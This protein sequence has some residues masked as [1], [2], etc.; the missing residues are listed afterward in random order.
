MDSSQALI[1]AYEALFQKDVALAQKELEPHSLCSES[2]LLRAR[3]FFEEGD[4]PSSFSYAVKSIY[5]NPSNI[6]AWAQVRDALIYL[7]PPLSEVTIAL[8]FDLL[9]NNELD[10]QKLSPY[11]SKALVPLAAFSIKELEQVPLY[12]E[13]ASKMLLIGWEW[14]KARDRQRHSLLD[15]FTLEATSIPFLA[16]LSYQ[17][18]LSHYLPEAE[19]KLLAKFQETPK[20]LKELLVKSCFT[21]L[22]P[23]DFAEVVEKDSS[24][25]EI[26]YKRF[27]LTK[28]QPQQEL[29]AT[30]TVLKQFYEENPYPRWEML[31]LFPSSLVKHVELSIEFG[32]GITPL[33]NCLVAGVGTGAHLL[34]LAARYP[35][36][37]FVGIDLSQTSLAFAQS[38][39]AEMQ[40]INP[41]LFNNVKLLQADLCQFSYPDGFDQPNGFDWIECVGVIHHLEEPAKGWKALHRLGKEKALLLGGVYHKHAR[42]QIHQ[43]KQQG[44]S[45]NALRE[46][47][48]MNPEGFVIANSPDFYSLHSCRDLLLHP[49][50]THYTLTSLFQELKESGWQFIKI[51]FSPVW[52]ALYRN[53]HPNDYRCENIESLLEFEQDQ[54]SAFNGM[55]LFWAEKI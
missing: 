54:P 6:R 5:A 20:N 51:E 25:Y 9:R 49:R 55:I 46:K 10:A 33:A 17:F 44:L 21:S 47:I 48:V 14:E 24:Y 35:Q 7:S 1:A 3:L 30:D 53:K 8:I 26:L 2:L 4:F 36:T 41:H 38:K 39:M 29:K 37:K 22:K 34:E 19:D 16:A 27:S 15:P 42:Q 45:L 12:Q 52:R 32:R 43:F 50:E 13:V 28:Q 11:L 18:Y 23:Q 31:D 40:A